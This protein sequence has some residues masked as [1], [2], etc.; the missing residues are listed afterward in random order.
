MQLTIQEK[1][2]N[3]LLDR[4]HVCGQISFEGATPSNSELAQA[5]AKELSADAAN[6][7][8]KHIYTSFGRQNANFDAVAYKTTEARSKTE[9]MTSHLRKKL[10]ESKKGGA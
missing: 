9:R 2:E 8:V 10:E 3:V 7:V 6:V 5:I 4:T 1:K